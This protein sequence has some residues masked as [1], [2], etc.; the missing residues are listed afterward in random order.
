MYSVKEISVSLLL[1]FTIFLSGCTTKKDVV[2]RASV[3]KEEVLQ[4]LQSTNA[5]FMQKWP[6]TGKPIFTTRWRPSNIWTRAVYYEGLMALYAIDPDE[7]YYDY[8]VDWG[9]KH[10]WGL[11]NGTATRN[12]DDQA[13]GQI[14]L[15]LYEIDPQ[16]ERIAA[17]KKNIDYVMQSEQVD[18]WTWIDAIQMAMPVFAKMG[19]MFKDKSYFDYMYAMYAYTKEKEGGGLYNTQD[20]LWWRDKDFVPPY[21]EPNG[22]DCY[23]S[24]GNGW[25]VA[26]LVRVLSL[27]PEDEA[28]RN[29]YMQDYKDLMAAVLKAQRA[30]GFWNVS[31]HDASNFGGRETSGTALFVYGM[32]WGIQQGFLDAEIYRPAVDKA[33]RAMAREAV[34]PSGFL[35]YVQ[36]TGKEPKDGQPV[37]FSSVPDFEDYG[38]GCFLLAGAEMYKLIARGK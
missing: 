28:H 37:S 27:L 5:Y 18:D 29:V 32:A 7:R 35:G 26:A 9:M 10:Q 2:Q 15:D 31:L 23:W 21:K 3:S 33:W 22:E 6:D 24:R 30:D 16:P 8:A 1:L 34:H 11:R 17:I 13:C 4:V 20:K 12:A 14:Y 19:V 36:G 38:L 25:V